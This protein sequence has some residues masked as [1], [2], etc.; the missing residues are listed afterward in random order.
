VALPIQTKKKSIY[1][2]ET[3][4]KKTHDITKT[5]IKAAL[6]FLPG[7]ISGDEEDIVRHV[8]PVDHVALGP[9]HGR[10]S[11]T[12]V[13]AAMVEKGTLHTQI[14]PLLNHQSKATIELLTVS[15]V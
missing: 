8:N 12:P 1:I 10:H 5:H 6:L 4:K 7:G 15:Y 3:E 14:T 11:P 9:S 13:H 2:T